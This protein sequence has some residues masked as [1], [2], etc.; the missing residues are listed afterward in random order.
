MLG[1]YTF[2]GPWVITVSQ[3]LGDEI[4][5]G[6]CYVNYMVHQS[7]ESCYVPK[8]TS[9]QPSEGEFSEKLGIFSEVEI[10][11]NPFCTKIPS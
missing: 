10:F 6:P 4:N 3:P 8:I 7:Y 9:F 5:Q 2:A 11:Q 1:I